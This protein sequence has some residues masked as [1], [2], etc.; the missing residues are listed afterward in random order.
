MPNYKWEKVKESNKY[1]WHSVVKDEL[2][3]LDK[4]SLNSEFEKFEEKNNYPGP[5]TFIFSDEEEKVVS[6]FLEI[7]KKWKDELDHD[8]VEYRDVLSRARLRDF[9]SKKSG[10]SRY[11]ENAPYYN[12]NGIWAKKCTKCSKEFP[13]NVKHWRK[14]S[15][16]KDGLSTDCLECR[17]SSNRE[18]GKKSYSNNPL[19]Q[20][21]N[22]QK[23]AEKTIS[24][25]PENSIQSKLYREKKGKI[26]VNTIYGRIDLL[27]NDKIFEIKS[28]KYWKHALGQILV[29]S[30]EYPNHQ[31]VL[32]LYGKEIPKNWSD[33][34]QACNHFNVICEF[35]VER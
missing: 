11:L 26:E 34:V 32:Y 4:L 19:K 9:Y 23:W 13:R 22:N 28:Y 8:F 16:S 24:E 3:R 17:R 1:D 6:I 27:T 12:V 21:I 15:S 7:N 20:K 35:H 33:I 31:M 29:Y 18:D 2:S 25:T 14:H 5:G 10:H 30:I